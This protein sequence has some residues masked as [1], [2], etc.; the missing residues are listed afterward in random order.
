[1]LD[2]N[3]VIKQFNDIHKDRYDYSLVYYTVHKIKS[4]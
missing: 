4:K 1:M 3:D 2:K